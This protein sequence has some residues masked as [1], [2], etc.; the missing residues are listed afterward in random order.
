LCTSPPKTKAI[1]GKG[2][3]YPAYF[4]AK[5][6]KKNPLDPLPPKVYTVLCF[7]NPAVAFG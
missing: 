4:Y 7:V 1:T 5:K 3:A 2:Q 6:K